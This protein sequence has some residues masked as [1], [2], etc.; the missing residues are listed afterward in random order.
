MRVLREFESHSFRHWQINGSDHRQAAACARLMAQAPPASRTKAAGQSIPE[1][2]PCW[3][4]KNI[5]MRLFMTTL[6]TVAP[7]F[8]SACGGTAP[9]NSEAASASAPA[10]VT[11][12][13]NAA[14]AQFAVGRNVNAALEGDARARAGARTS[15]VL[16]PDQV[17]TMEFNA[18]RLNLSVDS[19]GR[20]TRVSCG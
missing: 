8:I 3:P 18:E 15:R 1:Y 16:K 12:R 4:E 7:L 14:P 17:V 11:T 10:P 19:A 5:T 9:V 13:C 6:A 20:V 2:W